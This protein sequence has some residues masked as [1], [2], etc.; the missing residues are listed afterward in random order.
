MAAAKVD[1]IFTYFLLICAY[2]FECKCCRFLCLHKG[3]ARGLTRYVKYVSR[4]SLEFN[5]RVADI[6]ASFISLDDFVELKVEV[7]LFP[8]IH[9]MICQKV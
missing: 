9:K 4:S 3:L 8:Q 1:Q 6:I 2:C 7:T 5:Q